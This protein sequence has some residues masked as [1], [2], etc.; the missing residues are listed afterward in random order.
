MPLT[1][2]ELRLLKEYEEDVDREI[3]KGA[4]LRPPPLLTETELNVVREA[5]RENGIDPDNLNKVTDEEIEKAWQAFY[6]S[7][8]VQAMINAHKDGM[9]YVVTAEQHREALRTAM[10]WAYTAGGADQARVQLRIMQR[11]VEGGK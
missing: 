5:N 9:F 1:P 10:R 7:A 6:N 8:E 2:E 3:K 4:P 11:A